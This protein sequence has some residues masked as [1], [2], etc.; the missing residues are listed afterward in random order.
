MK[1]S[2]L[3][4]ALSLMMM[5]ST[6]AATYTGNMSASFV[7]TT[8]TQAN[9]S[10]G[11]IIHSSA[12][13]VLWNTSNFLEVFFEKIDSTNG[14]SILGSQYLNYIGVAG[15]SVN[16]GVA[17]LLTGLTAGHIYKV[18]PHMILH[19]NGSIVLLKDGTTLVFQTC[20][21]TVSS[22]TA[23]IC[24][25]NSTTLSATGGTSY[26][27]LPTLGLS[28]PNIANPVANPTVSTTYTVTVSG[29]CTTSATV[30]V[31]VKTNTTPVSVVPTS[32]IAEACKVSMDPTIAFT[33]SPAGG[34]LSCGG[35]TFTGSTINISTLTAGARVVTYTVTD[36]NGCPASVFT[37]VQIDSMP[38]INN[39]VITNN[40]ATKTVKVYGHLVG[41]LKMEIIGSTDHT[42][43]ASMQNSTL[44]IF[45]NVLY[46]STDVMY[47]KYNSECFVEQSFTGVNEVVKDEDVKIFPNPVDD[48]FHLE[49]PNGK[50]QIK[51]FNSLGQIVR[52][53][54]TEGGSSFQIDRDNLFSGLYF[55]TLTNISADGETNLTITKKVL[56]K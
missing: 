41:P 23:T 19:Q 3:I 20:G 56:V 8:Q 46:N 54:T 45:N 39:I 27:W 52:D 6:F 12:P 33:L 51:I 10:F 44:A 7:S 50:Y 17:Y 29:T 9:I 13:I 18:V 25:G 30:A 24:S 49:F 37:N 21:V 26:S 28:N 48:V 36:N 5:G 34:V 53:I 11:W 4:T 40:G 22:T 1:K 31:N 43:V 38:E 16:L 55:I 32:G 47:L 2:F 15:D 14:N 42:Y 35:I